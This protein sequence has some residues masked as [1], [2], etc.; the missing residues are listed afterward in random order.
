MDD[1]YEED[2]GYE[3]NLP[4]Q[5]CFDCGEILYGEEVHNH[6]EEYQ[7]YGETKYP[8]YKPPKTEDIKGSLSNEEAIRIER[9]FTEINDAMNNLSST[10]MSNFREIKNNLKSME[11]KVTQLDDYSTEIFP[12]VK[13]AVEETDAQL[14]DNI[15]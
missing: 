10:A 15:K 8:T 6:M 1:Y 11:D 12:K 2:Y 3:E 5:S 9:K 4:P 14:T 13:E 7:D